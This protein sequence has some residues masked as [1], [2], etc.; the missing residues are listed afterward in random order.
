M[1]EENRKGPGVFYA[2]VGVATL[3]VAI[4]GAT[5]AYFSASAPS[6]KG[7]ITGATKDISAN[8][9]TLNVSRV[10]LGTAPTGGDNLVPADF[11]TSITPTTITGEDVQRAVTAD[12]INNG[13]TGCHVWKIDA[14]TTEDVNAADL[15]LTLSLT[16]VTDAAQWSYVV[17]TDTTTN[18]GETVSSVVEK[19]TIP[20]TFGASYNTPLPLHSTSLAANEHVIR[21]VMVYL[22]NVDSSQN[23]DGTTGATDARGTYNG[24]VTFSAMGGNVKASFAA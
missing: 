4:I 2:V 7:V 6:S 24:T 23:A 15:R 13:Y 3:V 11:G 17:Y 19:N 8:T 16:G 10:S 20:T 1:E 14:A 5:F 12:C 22:N 21:Y 9:L 18:N